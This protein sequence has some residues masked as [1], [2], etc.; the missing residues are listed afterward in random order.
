MNGSFTSNFISPELNP[1]SGPEILQVIPLTQ[2]QI[3]IWLSCVVGGKEAN[4][5][6][7]ESN[8][9]RIRG[10][11]D[12]NALERAVETLV[13]RHESLRSSLSGDGKNMLVYKN[14]P[15]Q[16]SYEDISGRSTQEKSE[17]MEM[18]WL[19]EADHVFDLLAGPLFRATLLKTAEYGYHFTFTAHHLIIDGWSIGVVME[20][21]GK[22]YTAYV[23][24]LSPIL[25]SIDYFSAFA[26]N[27]NLLLKSQKYREVEEFWLD[28]YKDHVPVLDLPTDHP[29]PLTRTYQSSRLDH[30]LDKNLVSSLKIVGIRSGYTFV[31][32]LLTAFEVFLFRVT[33]QEDLVIGL[34]T[35]GQSYTGNYNLVG[36]CVNLL[37]IRSHPKGKLAFSEY[38]AL[39]K[40]ALYDAYEHQELTFGSLLKKL[41]TSRDPSRIP[42]VPVI[43]NVDIG[44]DEGVKFHHL[45]WEMISNPKK[46]LNFEWFLNVNGSEKSVVLEWTYNNYLFG[47]ETMQ[48][49]MEG[50]TGLLRQLVLNPNIR[51][52]DISFPHNRLMEKLKEWNRTSIDFL[53]DVPIT[54]FIHATAV[55]YSDKIAI[56][57]NDQNITYRELDQVSNQLATYL[58]RIGVQKEDIIG[59]SVDRS[60]EMV[61]VL[62]GILKAG[63][64]YLPLDPE[65]PRDR[66]EYM[67]KDSK[68]KLLLTNRKLEGNIDSSFKKI[69]IED[70]LIETKG[71]SSTCPEVGLMGKSLA[72]ILY[73]S[74]STGHPKGVQIEHHNLVNFLLSMQIDPGIGSEDRLLAITTISF[75]IAGL[76]LYLPLMTGATMVL[77]DT[78]T[79]KDGRLL[80][81]W[82]K[83]KNITFMQ[84]TP[85]TWRMLLNSGWDNPLP[86]KILCGGE[87]LS[88]DLAEK[89]LGKAKSVWNVYGPTETTIWSTIKNLNPD[90]DIITIGR[91][92]KN[93]QIYLLD[94]ERDLV[95]LGGVGEIYIGGEGVAR[96]YLN[97]EDLTK[98]RFFEDPFAGKKEGARM[99]RTGDLGKFQENGEVICLGRVDHQVKIRGYRIELGE[100]EVWMS[101]LDGVKEAVVMAREDQSENQRIV[102]YLVLQNKAIDLPLSPTKDQIS[103]WKKELQK[104][105]PAYMIPNDWVVLNTFPLTANNKI[106]R[107]SLPSPNDFNV[108]DK[109]TT[110]VPTSPSQKL[111]AA[112][113]E[114]TLEI[115]DI[116]LGN[117]FFELG[118]HSLVAV[119]VMIMVEKETGEKLPLDSLFKHPT[120]GEFCALLEDEQKLKEESWAS[121]VPI[122]ADGNKPPLYLVHAAGSHV[123]TYY[124]LAK[125]LHPD[126]PVFGLQAKGLNGIDAPLTTLKDMA[127]H[128]ISEILAHNPHGPYFIGGH[129]FGGYVAYE[130]AKQLKQMNKEVK[131]LIL[132]DIYAYQSEKELTAWEKL[133]RRVLDEILK[134]YV[135]IRLLF[136]APQTFIGLKKFSL[137]KKTRKIMRFLKMD[138]K[139]MESE[140][141]HT[142][143]KIRRINHQAMDNYLLSPYNGEI[144]LFKAAV[145]NFFAPDGIN[146]GWKPYVKKINIIE[147]KGD[148]NTMF[149]EP[150][151][152]D[153]GRKLQSV[154]DK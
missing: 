2:S 15:N 79:G 39:R 137:E 35:S 145:Q 45:E 119:E 58:I 82:I 128:Y 124:T 76:E 88:Q 52:K 133:K 94:D 107:K 148:H 28:L 12:V 149:I 126:Q 90:D 153:M 84:A 92:I 51:I 22:L 143:E 150:L 108:I 154:L 147:I 115:S 103:S 36:H 43:F 13:E 63:A 46:F 27:Q 66:I 17:A 8:S 56:Q 136:T 146:Y 144:H 127:A 83:E 85:A 16:F 141:F 106:D 7:N 18:H 14:L 73:T 54:Q 67:L 9:L 42:L 33:G 129:S 65:Y 62:L 87:A 104:S 25:P 60:P 75:D 138:T 78:E 70:I 123:S 23:Q 37:P 80:L 122:K 135:E 31:N 111:I 97:R 41:K 81:K 29:R 49:M 131:K 152:E 38:M 6:Y 57:F 98:D 74:G 110:Q 99:Y 55:K 50:F 118:G 32:T 53:K 59:V 105:L 20:E 95:D 61:M 48:K 116:G 101:R 93:T 40:S 30:K 5:A 10:P 11:L 130:M 3:E 142:I 96:G 44:M 100:I 125:K 114:K 86:I 21:L 68:A 121:L 151:V 24:D 1:F 139:G 117:D 77:A 140:R 71:F 69:F 109:S 134:R 34:P 47:Q 132:F 64:A 102:G 72:Y 112:I 91:P 120:L 113:W 4:R 19:V 89:L 26:K